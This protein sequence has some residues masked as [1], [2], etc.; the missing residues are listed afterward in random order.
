MKFFHS[1]RTRLTLWFSA[2]LTLILFAFGGGSYLVIRST[3]S[4][5]LDRSLRNEAIWLHDFITPRIP[6]LRPG[7]P[8][9][10]PAPREL[11]QPLLLSDED[12]LMEIDEIDSAWQQIYKHTILH[13]RKRYISIQQ[14]SGKIIYQSPATSPLNIDFDPIAEGTV[15]VSTITD[16]SDNRL[17]LALIKT[18]DLRISVAYPLSELNEI[19]ENLYSIFVILTPVALFLAVVGGWFLADRSLRPVKKIIEAVRQITVRNLDQRLPIREADDEISRLAMTFNDMIG[20]LKS[21]VE[22]MQQFSLDASHELRTPLT[23]IRG[24]VEVAL[25]DKKVQRAT[26]K[27][28]SSIHEELLRLSAIVDGLL[29]LM[30]SDSGRTSFHFHEV[31]LHTLIN[32]V[33][34]DAI[35]LAST[36]GIRVSLEQN[37]HSTILG[38]PI[39]LRQLFR[40]LI[41]NAVKYTPRHGTITISHTH[42]DSNAIVSIRDTG[43]GIS[44][45]ELSAV[46]DRFYRTKQGERATPTGSGLGLSIAK[47]IAESHEGSIAVQSRL[48]EGSTFTVYLPLAHPKTHR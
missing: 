40:N 43:I 47:W 38:D 46:F 1:I 28:L 23:I 32:D 3:L 44:Q 14:T 12:S 8:V 37:H 19:L 6:S 26:R 33:V 39:R 27:I 36:K 24:E 48:R 4:D 30:K 22:K 7:K 20:R 25:R 31:P 45:R 41:D 13:P 2:W 35:V 5:N 21:S 10:T 18:S 16:A 42:R 29:L 15:T 17:R 11:V 9:D 34:S